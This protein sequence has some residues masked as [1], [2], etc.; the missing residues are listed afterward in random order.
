MKKLLQNISFTKNEIKVILFLT[1]ILIISIGFKFYR[2]TSASDTVY[3][4][5][6]KINE[7]KKLSGNISITNNQES[8]NPAE[9]EGLFT[10]EEIEKIEYIQLS[11]DSLYLKKGK[12]TK[13]GENLQEKSINL[14]T[15][16]KDLLILLPGVGDSTAEK[17]ISYRTE[18]GR[19][20]SIEEIM[21][22]KG[23]GKKKFEKM[24][25]YIYVD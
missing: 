24:Q 23:I 19:F 8:E 20:N 9:T 11:E 22:V 16:G 15:A 7:F 25:A 17:I 21:K 3:D 5:T 14:N 10:Q 2:I 6:D 18:H 13:K 1:A 12:K 4:Y